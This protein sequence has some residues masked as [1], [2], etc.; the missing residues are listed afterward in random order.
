MPTNYDWRGGSGLFNAA[1]N[2]F[3]SVAPTSTD[4]VKF[5]TG[6]GGTIGGNG[7]AFDVTTQTGTGPWT[8]TGALIA[9]SAH[10]YG[11]TT[12]S[13]GSGLTLIGTNGASGYFN[14]STTYD[15]ASI[16]GRTASVEVGYGNSAPA[17]LTLTNGTTATLTYVDVARFATSTGA[18]NVSGASTVLAVAADATSSSGYL[19]LGYAGGTGALNMSAGAT[20]IID[21]DVT[22][23]VEA[24]GTGTTTIDAS[25]LTVKGGL[26]VGWLGTGALTLQNGGKL[27]TN[28]VSGSVNTATALGFN[29]GASGT[30]S[31]TGANSLWTATSVSVGSSGTG[32]VAVGSGGALTAA[33]LDL[34]SAKGGN[35]TLTVNA[36]GTVSIVKAFTQT[37]LLT[38]G[39]VFSATSTA[40]GTVTVQDIG[41]LLDTGI[42]GASFGG[43]NSQLNV[44]AGGTAKFGSSNPAL[45]TSLNL[46]RYGGEATATIDGTDS[47]LQ[48]RNVVIGK[49]GLGHM[50]VSHNG[51][52][53]LNGSDIN[54]DG[55]VLG[56]NNSDG[57]TPV[58]GGGDLTVNSGGQVL[59]GG[60]TFGVANNPN[61][62]GTIS[63]GA[64]GTIRSTAAANTTSFT[65]SIASNTNSNATTNG[66]VTVAGSGALIDMGNNSTAIGNS[67][68]GTFIVG[69]G[70]TAKS[71]SADSRLISALAM[72]RN[73]T[74]NAK[75]TISGAGASYTATGYTYIGRAGTAALTVDQ[76]GTFTA[77]LAATG[78]GTGIN[79]FQNVVV[80]DGTSLVDSFGNPNT[81][82]LGGTST[83][84]VGANGTLHTLAGLTVGRNGSTGALTIGGTATPRPWLTAR[85]S[86]GPERTTPAPAA[87]SP[88]TPAAACD[89]QRL[90]AERGRK[91]RPRQQH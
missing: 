50:T 90:G 73:A 31:I 33:Q 48:A 77:G 56:F 36:G 62:K 67:G 81:Q 85:S 20:G 43:A 89:V 12:F 60:G 51:T 72:G 41:A 26:R 74:G 79:G 53:S 61:A 7:A 15:G 19:A 34:A 54:N 42:N 5:S 38:V 44:L 23:G 78:D 49:A 75:L 9:D 57:T 86:S 69:A 88:S 1:A 58:G 6:P 68:N 27:N 84:T 24:G 47:L 2:W 14:G 80:G 25:T 46:G 10:L 30:A 59:L 11:T 4:Y 3:P 13:S 87:P 8:F 55:L 21:R 17:S 66:S 16:G 40:K 29:P 32:S 63:V 65:L 22:E 52:L 83:A 82:Y 28:A 76:G 39:D 71:A 70:G 35:G 64:G 91:H 37:A 45:L 18:L